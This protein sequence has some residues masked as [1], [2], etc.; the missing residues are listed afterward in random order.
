MQN[1][2]TRPTPALP[3]LKGEVAPK[4]PEGFTF[5]LGE[6]G[7]AQALTKEDLSSPVPPAGD[8]LLGEG[9]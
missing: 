8:R 5:P 7:S 3:P 6:G 1:D 9:A 4:E 2:N